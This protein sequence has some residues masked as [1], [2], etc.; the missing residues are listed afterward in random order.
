MKRCLDV[1]RG[2][3]TFP[4]VPLFRLAHA[5]PGRCRPHSV[6]GE[7]TFVEE[8]GRLELASDSFDRNDV[9]WLVSALRAG[10]DPDTVV[11]TAPG[12]APGRM[13]A[14]YRE[15][16]SRRARSEAA[17]DRVRANPT[18]GTLEADGDQ[19]ARLLPVPVTRLRTGLS[20]DV[21]R[22]LEHLLVEV[23]RSRDVADDIAARA[24][25]LSGGPAEV[26]LLGRQLWSP[27]AGCMYN[28]PYFL[29]R[30]VGELSPVRVSD[31]LGVRRTSDLT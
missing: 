30:R 2:V 27:S 1:L 3:V 10:A 17:W 13:L 25:T 29:P 8:L 18:A 21:D 9:T 26:Q 7:A 11:R 28:D 23:G 22:V 6:V 4:V 24:E 31:L 20:G 12:V 14:A 15:L 16:E 5:W 19:A